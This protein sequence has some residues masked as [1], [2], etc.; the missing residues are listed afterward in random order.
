LNGSLNPVSDYYNIVRP[1]REQE[2]A[3]L[4]QQRQLNAHRER[5]DQYAAVV[6]YDLQGD[7]D[8]APTGHSTTYMF[9]NNFQETGNY[10]PGVQGLQKQNITQQQ[11]F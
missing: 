1:Q 7:E 6:P 4:Q 8:A 2:R 5:V 9:F 3:N 11:S 10:F